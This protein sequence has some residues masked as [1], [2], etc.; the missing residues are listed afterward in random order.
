MDLC[1]QSD[2]SGFN[3]LSRFAIA[4]LPRSKCLLISWL[5][6][7]STV[8]LEPQ[9]MQSVTVSTVYPS[10]C[11]E[12]MEPDARIL[13]F[14]VWSFKLAF[15]LSS[16]TLT[17]T[18]V[19]RP[20]RHLY[21]VWNAESWGSLKAS[22]AGTC[23]EHRRIYQVWSRETTLTQSIAQHRLGGLLSLG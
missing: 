17:D 18:A 15:S 16:F 3:T 8:V 19:E 9:K 10:I 6:S 2:V 14:W 20:Q 23:M 5:Q 12:V 21:V 1:W 7:P 11:L 22:D 13:V 4:F